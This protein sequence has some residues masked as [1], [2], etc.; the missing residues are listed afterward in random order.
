ML[1]II[2]IV[3]VIVIVIAVFLVRKRRSKVHLARLQKSKDME[4]FLDDF[5]SPTNTDIH[6]GDK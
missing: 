2:A 1:V 6:K 5:S 3:I 4:D